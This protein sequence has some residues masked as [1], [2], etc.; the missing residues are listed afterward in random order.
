MARDERKKRE[1]GKDVWGGEIERKRKG[2]R[3]LLENLG[4]D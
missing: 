3:P 2:V 4:W 1:E